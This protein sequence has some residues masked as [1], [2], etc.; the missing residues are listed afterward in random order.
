MMFVTFAFYNALYLQVKPC[1]VID[2]IHL[3]LIEPLILCNGIIGFAQS[4]TA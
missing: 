3:D 2:F 4:F 1:R